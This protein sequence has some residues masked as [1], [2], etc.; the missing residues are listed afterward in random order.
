MSMHESSLP[1]ITKQLNVFILCDKSGSMEGTKITT[2]NETCAELIPEIKDV[3]EKESISIKLNVLSFSDKAEWMYPE[4][5]DIEEYQWNELKADGW[6]QLGSALCELNDKL[7]KEK[8]LKAKSA[9]TAP[10][11]LLLSDGQPTDDYKPALETLKQKRWFKYA[12]KCCIAIGNDA[13]QDVLAEFTGDP[14]AVITVHTPEA[15]RKWIKVV[16]LTSTQIGSHS[17]TRDGLVKDK[18]EQF[19]EQ[20]QIAQEDPD[21]SQMSTRADQWE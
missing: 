6:T 15:L 18:N 19:V 2:V 16:S 14:N 17:Y 20:I 11:I 12:I 21:L 13:D 3:A 10:V 4:P 9:S 7:S 5:K 8:F 1:E